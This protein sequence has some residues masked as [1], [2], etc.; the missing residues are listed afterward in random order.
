MGTQAWR[1]TQHPA[2]WSRVVEAPGIARPVGAVTVIDDYPRHLLACHF[3][4]S[5]RAQRL[6]AAPEAART[7]AES[8]HRRR[9]KTPFLVTDNGSSFLPRHCRSHIDGC[10]RDV[11]IHH[12][13]PRQR[14]LP[15]RF[16][17]TLK[18][19]E[20]HRQLHASPAHARESPEVFRQR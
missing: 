1:T 10:Y 15:E 11:C 17:Q 16:H 6:T 7:E 8:R 19:G 4:T 13:T 5:D 18:T 9:T 2:R 12:R 20:M 14:G 3:T